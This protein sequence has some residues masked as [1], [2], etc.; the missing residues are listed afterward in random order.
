[1]NWI[2]IKDRLPKLGSQVMVYQEALGMYH[3]NTAILDRIP[4]NEDEYKIVW[5]T[6]LLGRKMEIQ[7]VEFWAVMPDPPNCA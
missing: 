3:I 6:P 4:L 7:N 2:N 5:A 1:M